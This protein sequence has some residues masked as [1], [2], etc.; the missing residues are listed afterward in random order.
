MLFHKVYDS[1]QLLDSSA[2]CCICNSKT[3]VNY[4]KQGK[5]LCGKV[6]NKTLH[7][8]SA[9]TDLGNSYIMGCTKSGSKSRWLSWGEPR[10]FKD[11]MRT[12]KCK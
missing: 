11:N 6:W 2:S 5:C 3:E 4:L 7:G 10:S 1:K 9:G 12:Q 8:T